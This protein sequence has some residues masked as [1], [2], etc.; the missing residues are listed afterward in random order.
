MGANG[1]EMV[2]EL[3]KSIYGLKQSGACW[4]ARLTEFLKRSNFTRCDTDPCLWKYKHMNG[5]LLLAVYVDDLI[6]AAKCEN[7]RSHVMNI[8]T[9]EFAIKDS[10]ELTWVLGTHIEQNLQAGI[11]TLD[12]SLYIQDIV[13]THTQT[14][15]STETLADEHKY[16]TRERTTPCDASILELSPLRADETICPEY[17]S[18]LGKLSWVAWMSRPDICFTVAYLSRFMSGGSERHMRHLVKLLGYLKK[19]AHYKLT[20]RKYPVQKFMSLIKAN[21]AMLENPIETVGGLHYCTDSSYGGERPPAGHIGEFADGPVSWAAYRCPITPLSSTEGE[22]IAGTRTT[23]SAIA[24]NSTISFCGEESDMPT[25][26]FCDNL[27]TVQLSD[28]NLSSKRMK[29]IATRIAF[30][31]ENVTAKH[32][33]LIHVHTNGQIADIF[34]KP[35]A[36]GLFHRFREAILS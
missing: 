7:L 11:T 3:V 6:I 35:L 23:V 31:R 30:L 20:Y 9:N 29:H 10:G 13:H 5:T 18:L 2:Y 8:I 28:G 14:N 12:Q 17:R 34:T 19:T 33:V 1:E 21:S 22:Y 36:A 15:E 25:I 26:I 24:A 27:G 16:N 4:E 32:V